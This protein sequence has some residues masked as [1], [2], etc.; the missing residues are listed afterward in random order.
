MAALIFHPV[1]ESHVVMRPYVCVQ[2]EKFLTANTQELS[3]D[4]WLC[5]LSGKKFKVRSAPCVCLCRLW[6]GGCHS[7]MF[8]VSRLLSLCE[9]TS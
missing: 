3:K 5:P 1:F 2:V 9:N 8:S 7:N 4:K 6:F